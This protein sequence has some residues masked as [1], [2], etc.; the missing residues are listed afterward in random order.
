MA[1]VYSS[2]PPGSGEQVD[3]IVIG[4]G[5]VGLAVARGLALAGREVVVLEAEAH[6][7]TGT[8]SRNSEVIHAGIYYPTGSLKARLCVSGRRLLYRYCAAKSVPH[9]NLGKVIVATSAEELPILDFYRRQA[10]A[11]GVDDL[12]PLDA[13]QVQDLEPEV[14]CVGG[15]LSPST[16][17]VDSHALMLALQADLEEH[18]GI[19]V[20]N[21]P[22]IGGTV[23]QNEVVVEVYGSEPTTLSA[24]LAVNCAGLS[25]QAVSRSFRDVPP[26]SIPPQ[27]L[28]KGYYFSLS[29]RSPFHRL[30][31]PIASS[32]GLGIHVTLDLSGAARFGPDVQWVDTIDYH[33][34]ESRRTTFAEA[35]RRYYPALDETRLQPAHTGIRPKISSPTDPAADFLIRGPVNHA[36]GAYVALYGIE[37][38]G[39]TAS[40]AIAEHVVELA[41]LQS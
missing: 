32:A 18:G 4:A 36:G 28:A 6:I 38:P 39:L 7:G 30:V 11:N 31:Y 26:A 34:D 17:I 10:S 20:C 33:H 25:S 35:I 9:R 19:V 14:Y 23:R 37:S 2:P 16:G 27:Y 41:G 8:S 1:P 22:V 3:C 5:V 15:L 40:L 24:K 12:V 13:A 21:S 29:G